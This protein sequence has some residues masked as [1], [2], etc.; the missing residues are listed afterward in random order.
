MYSFSNEWTEAIAIYFFAQGKHRWQRAGFEPVFT[1]FIHSATL[2]SNVGLWP[3]KHWGVFVHILVD[4]YPASKNLWRMRTSF[5]FYSCGL[6]VY[7]GNYLSR[8]L[9]TRLA[10]G[11]LL[12]FRYHFLAWASPASRVC[13]AHALSHT[14]TSKGILVFFPEF[15]Q[16]V[17][18][19]N[20][21]HEIFFSSP[22][23]CQGRFH[24]RHKITYIHV[25]LSSTVLA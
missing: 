6:N 5:Y 12:H 16:T 9:C 23:H 11:K 17:R 20:S 22:F 4:Y 1:P 2:K 21:K 3:S 14:P 24:A 19:V 8:L 7:C 10:R 18:T 15:I 13:Y 25:F